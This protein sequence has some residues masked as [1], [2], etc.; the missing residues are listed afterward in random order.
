MGRMIARRRSLVRPQPETQET[1]GGITPFWIVG[2]TE[3]VSRW[4][5]TMLSVTWISGWGMSPTSLR[6][7]ASQC[8]PGADHLFLPPLRAAVQAARNSDLLV[9]WS[10][11]AWRL[12]QAGAEGVT[13]PGQVCLLSPFVAFC[14][15]YCLGGRSSIS[16]VRWLARWI[17]RD[18]SAALTDFRQRA[19]L[20]A[21][22]KAKMPYALPDLLEGLDRLAEDAPAELRRFARERLPDNWA[23]MVGEHDP[24]LDARSVGPSIRNCEVIPAAT[25]AP[26]T[27]AARLIGVRDAF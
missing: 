13:F 14:S 3:F 22:D 16:Q 2:A 24:L 7:V 23:A 18:A 15:D 25:H 17:R 9:G 19:G 26:E 27:F 1:H 5:D 20:S 4:L 6:P 10:F 8:F 12:L 11:G 21:T